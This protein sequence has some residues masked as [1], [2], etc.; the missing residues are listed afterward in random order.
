MSAVNQSVSD[1][2]PD[3]P[4]MRRIQRGD[5]SGCI[6]VSDGTAR[7]AEDDSVLYIIPG[8]SVAP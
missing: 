6:R 5:G 1:Y 2:F 7:D 8:D 3:L 4:R